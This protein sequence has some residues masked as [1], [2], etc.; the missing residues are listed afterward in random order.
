MKL[1]YVNQIEGN[2]PTTWTR[3]VL[4]N[5]ILV[6]PRVLP[7]K[8]FV[9]GSPSEKDVKTS[10]QYECSNK[11]WLGI[12]KKKSLNGAKEN[13]ESAVAGCAWQAGKCWMS[14]HSIMEIEEVMEVHLGCCSVHAVLTSEGF[15]STCS[16]KHL[17][18]MN[19]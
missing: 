17:P 12:Y 2:L 13:I 8:L 15:L 19:F 6:I 11:H 9:N 5:P 16:P 10:I 1:Q 18:E 7:A 14:S 3:S 4:Q